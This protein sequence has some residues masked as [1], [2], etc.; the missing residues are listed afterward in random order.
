VTKA[1]FGEEWKLYS[2]AQNTLI[3]YALCNA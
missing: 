2:E 3:F 1:A